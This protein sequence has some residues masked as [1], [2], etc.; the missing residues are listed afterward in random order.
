MIR[1]F[2]FLLVLFPFFSFSQVITGVDTIRVCY[3]G[4]VV[5]ANSIPG[6]LSSIDFSINN[7]DTVFSV[8]D[9]IHSPVIDLGFDFDFYGVSYDQVIISTNGYLSFDIAQAGTNSQWAINSDIPNGANTD[10]QN[11]IMCPYTDS[12][13]GPN[14]NMI[15]GTAGVA[16]NRVFVVIWNDFEMYGFQCN[17]YCYSSSVMIFEGNNK[18]INSIYNYDHCLGWNSGAGV[19]GLYK[20]NTTALIVNDP[21][22][23]N[24][25]NFSNPWNASTESWIYTPQ[26]NTYNVSQSP[27]FI[28]LD[29]P[30]WYDANN[31]LLGHGYSINYV[32]PPISTIPTTVQ[33]RTE[34]CG[35]SIFVDIPVILDCPEVLVSS[36]G[37][38]CVGAND[39]KVIVNIP[40]FCGVQAVM[41]DFELINS[42]GQVIQT[43]SD[44]VFPLYFQNV[45]HGVYKVKYSST[46]VD[47]IGEEQIIVDILYQ[48]SNGHAV[49]DSVSCFGGTDGSIKYVAIGGQNKDWTITLR[50][51]STNSVI[52]NIQS[53]S[54]TYQTEF[55]FGNLAP[56]TYKVEANS[57]TTC[58][59]SNVFKVEEPTLLEFAS[60]ELDHNDCNAP[61]SSIHFDATGG[62]KPYQ[63]FLNGDKQ[64][65]LIK[66]GLE[67]GIYQIKIVDHRG[68]TIEKEI[69][70]YDMFSPKVDFSV[71]K[72]SF[73][74]NLKDATVH[75]KNKTEVNAHTEIESFWWEFGDGNSSAEENPIHTYGHI[76]DYP[77]HFYVTDKNGCSSMFRDTVRIVSP[78]FIFPNVFTPN[79]DGE[80]EFFKPAN[81]KIAPED[82]S[83][84]IYNRWGELIFETT[85]INE[86]WSGHNKK[87]E[88]EGG[89]YV[90]YCKYKDIYGYSH[91][92]SGTVQLVR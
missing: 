79:Y 43:A 3:E 52:D 20:D 9:D 74:Y 90:Y 6:N 66:D 34:Q 47:C 91:N 41:W 38:S 42:S 80:N 28:N 7:F 21:I 1:F 14:S 31:N 2:K 8:V 4:E 69:E 13:P 72:E 62:T 88:I 55:Y 56:G 61:N 60:Q 77:V 46:A 89:T 58:F 18:I 84:I 70:I 57:P 35:D 54:G 30:Y 32:A 5:P 23:G 33:L 44:S 25:R 26:G 82:Y 85:D 51:N 49:V 71:D 81:N 22:T 17:Q 83:L 78:N 65:N 45:P 27:G 59:T 63:Y 15:Y 37:E 64:F 50:D 29:R 19:Q 75:F 12:E 40:D 36:G 86:G 68:C 76:G 24:P 92:T 48:P 16:P 53:P 10:A 67:T 87:G 39:G 11:S 73:E